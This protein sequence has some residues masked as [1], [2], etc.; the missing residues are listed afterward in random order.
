MVLQD[1]LGHDDVTFT[2]GNSVNSDVT[3]NIT[4]TAQ[5]GIILDRHYVHW[6]CSPTRRTFLTGRLPLHHSEF[7]SAVNGDDI[8]LR[9]TTIAQKLKPAGYATYWYG[10]GHTGYKSFNHLPLQLGFDAFTGFLGG[11]QDHFSTGR[12]QGNCP[13]TP[14]NDSYCATL[15]GGMAHATLVDYDATAPNAKPLFFYLPWQNVHAPYEAPV[16]WQGDVLRGMLAATDAALGNIVDTLKTKG[17]WANSVIFY[18]ADNG[19]T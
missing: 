6:H 10:K 7:L 14:A 4:A 19:G 16:A 9:W 15:Y 1:D 11:A 8:D 5:Q 18:S 2:N 13:L 12:W 17:M 3:G